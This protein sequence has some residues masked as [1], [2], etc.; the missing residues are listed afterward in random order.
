MRTIIPV[1]VKHGKRFISP[2]YDVIDFWPYLWLHLSYCC[3]SKLELTIMPEFT[4]TQWMLNKHR[5]NQE[6]DWEVFAQCVR[7]AMAKYGNFTM[8]DMPIKEKLAYEKFMN[9]SAE[10][11]SVEG[12]TFTL[13]KGGNANDEYVACTK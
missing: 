3:I 2:C 1:F 12:E 13:Q 8:S 6:N 7:E 5:K 10:Q 11:Y 4:P 9:T